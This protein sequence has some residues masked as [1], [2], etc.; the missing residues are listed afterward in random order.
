MGIM[1]KIR[2]FC[3]DRPVAVFL[4]ACAIVLFGRFTAAGIAQNHPEIVHG[5]YEAEG[6]AVLPADVPQET[7]AD[8]RSNYSSTESE[9]CALLQASVWDAGGRNAVFGETE[10]RIRTTSETEESL[11]WAV[12]A[13]KREAHS[14]ASEGEPFETWTFAIATSKGTEIAKLE[15][16]RLEDGG[17]TSTLTCPL[18]GGGSWRAAEPVGEIALDAPSPEWFSE[19]GADPTT[20]RRDL[21]AWCATWAPTAVKATWDYRAVVDYEAGTITCTL[22]L[23]DQ[24]KTKVDMTVRLADGTIEIGRAS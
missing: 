18:F 16:V 12:S 6:E 5:G 1:D 4:I 23:D 10:L 3:Q 14:T 8:M 2:E 20:A 19:V 7:L 15:R 21:S 17:A 11:A 13:A 22:V 24:S 9:L